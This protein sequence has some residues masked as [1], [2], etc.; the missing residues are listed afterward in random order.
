M[1]LDVTLG[2]FFGSLA[3]TVTVSLAVALMNLR[4]RARY[5]KAKSA[6]LDELIDQLLPSE[7]V[8][9]DEK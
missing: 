4:A 6:A 8:E 7:A 2:V 1:V 5:N 9:E 3:A